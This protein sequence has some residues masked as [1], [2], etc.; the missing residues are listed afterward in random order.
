MISRISN[1]LPYLYY[2]SYQYYEKRHKYEDS[3][4]S[5]RMVV[6]GVELMYLMVFVLIPLD[7]LLFDAAGGKFLLE[8]MREYARG[9]GFIILGPFAFLYYKMS[10]KRVESY[11]YMMNIWRNES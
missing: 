7:I 11:Y 2:R 9:I 10:N 1:I 3:K 4:S 8:S 6:Y 5:A